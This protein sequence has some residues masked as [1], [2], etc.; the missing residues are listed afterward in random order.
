MVKFVT[1]DENSDNQRLDNFLLKTLKGVPKSKVYNIIRK[2]EVRVNKG[3]KKAEYKLQIGDI[4]RIPPVRVSEKTT[5]KTNNNLTNIIKNNIIFEDDALLVINKPS[6]TAVHSG[7][8]IEIGLIE[9]VKELYNP[10]YE[11]VHR[12]DRA[13]SGII[14]I[15]KKRKFLKAL[16][17]QIVAGK[18]QK[19]YQAIVAHSWTKKH[20][21]VDA[22]LLT[23]NNKTIVDTKG[24]EALSIFTPTHNFK[25]AG[26][27]L[28]LVDIEIK[29]GRNHQIRVHSVYKN[30]PILGDN[31]YGNFA[32]NKQ[33]KTKRMYLHNRQMIFTHPITHKEFI[34]NSP[35]KF[36]LIDNKI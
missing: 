35:H 36:D 28:S 11:L 19:F 16:Q 10:N 3:R 1:I 31:K 13:T 6:G 15:A 25:V 29:T 27:D 24:K 30:H 18:V 8:G 9:A 32:I 5:T 33:L 23:T 17:A 12:I 7:S 4:V 20:H 26:I 14:L 21:T 34:I 22:P 2:G